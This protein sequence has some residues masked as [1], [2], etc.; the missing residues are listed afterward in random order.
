MNNPM[1]LS[2]IALL[3][4]EVLENRNLFMVAPAGLALVLFVFAIWAISFAPTEQIVEG[5]EYLAILFDGLSPADMAPIFLVPASPFM[6]LLYGCG[7]IYLLNS[8]YQDRKD[9]SVFFW[10]S[11]PVSNLSTVLSKVVTLAVV[12]PVFYIAVLFVMYLL[13]VIGL[14]VLGMTYDIEVAG[15]GYMFMAAVA[16]L[17]LFY[18]SVVLASLW[19]LPTIGWVL[20]FSAFANRTPLMWAIGV[21][22]LLGFLE[23]F[24]FGSQFLANWVESR[25]NFRQYIVLEF[26]SFP[27]RLFSYDMFF[28]VVV[29]SILI[30]G[31]VYMRRFVD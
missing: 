6:I 18:L 21:Y 5:V 14:S 27:E 9:L 4:R 16:S 12:V 17:F 31:A 13:G 3:R 23:D 20:L 2:F 22:I 15:L 29:G 10:Q 28:G 30:A 26:S 7:L 25:A 19:L 24:V 1:V 8:L 11:M